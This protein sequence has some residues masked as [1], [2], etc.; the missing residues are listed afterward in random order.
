MLNRTEPEPAAEPA[1]HSAFHRR[2]GSLPCSAADCASTEAVAC[3]YVDRRSRACPTAWCL[4][5]QQ[6]A[7]DWVYCRR[8]AGIIRALGPQWATLALPDID[9]RAPSLANW[10]GMELNEPVRNL[11]ERFFGSHRLHVTTVV[12]GGTPRDRTWGRS[13]KLISPEGIDLSVGIVVAESDDCVVRLSYDGRV[14]R[15]VVPPWIE[16]RQRGIALDPASDA[17]ARRRFN[18]VMLEDLEAAMRDT[19]AGRTPWAVRQG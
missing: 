17:A 2:R 5:H 15:Q 9:N 19:V 10:V 8:H 11:L 14:L 3:E 13:W 16:A 6:V 7:F 1:A 12:S 18:G 4:V